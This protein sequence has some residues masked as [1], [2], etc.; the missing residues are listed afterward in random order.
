MEFITRGSRTSSL[1]A[2]ADL[3]MNEYDIN[4]T[5]GSIIQGDL[6]FVE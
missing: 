3:N 1:I 6:S 2:D 4:F 5:T